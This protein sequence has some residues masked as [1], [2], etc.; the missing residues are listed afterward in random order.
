MLIGN[1]D[2]EDAMSRFGKF[3]MNMHPNGSISFKTDK[4]D[5]DD[6]EKL[7]QFLQ[8]NP[9]FAPRPAVQQAPQPQEEEIKGE[10]FHIIIEKYKERF[11]KK[12]APKTLYG[13]LRNIAIFREWAEEHFKNKDFPVTAVNRKII[14]LY[15]NH[16]RAK[17]VNDNTIAKNY[18]IPLNGF[19]EFATSIGDYPDVEAPSRKHNLI[20]ST[21]KIE[22][23]RNPF[24]IAELRTIF[25]PQ[26]LPRNGHPEQFWAPLIALF[27][28]GRIS[29]VCQLHRIDIGKRDDFY[30]MSI[31]DEGDGEKRLK[32]GASKRIVPIHPVLIQ[33]GLIDFCEDMKK[34]GGQLFPTVKPD[35][36]GYYG[37]EPGRRWATYLN[38][39]GITDSTKVFHSF[40]TTANVLMMD[41]G[42]DEE[43]R[44][45]FIGHEHHTTN[46][47]VYKHK[48][49]ETRG[50]FTPEFLH[51]NV[52]PSMNYDI[53]FSKLRYERG[54]FDK[55][56]HKTL[57]QFE[58]KEARKVRLEE[59]GRTKKK[60]S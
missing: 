35:I 55:F 36:F 22:K 38:K 42:I 16:L 17:E 28:G 33:I 10:P 37:K 45:A 23:P 56:I 14:A 15:I 58:Q 24:E 48:G 51:E 30:T 32:S 44:C 9:Q 60:D 1:K 49:N 47:K 13:Y 50:K 5:P 7:G 3:E 46:S 25:D 26:N 11:D 57:R 27:T 52:M 31:T 4:D 18:L 21:T 6:V 53:D 2:K 19:F 20:D 41:K 54:M 29:E 8:K 43:R 39:I 12:R 40:R 59:L 34:F